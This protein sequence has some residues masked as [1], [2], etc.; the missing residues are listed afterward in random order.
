MIL[1]EDLRYISK[2]FG[3]A[4]CFTGKSVFLTGAAGFL[5]FYFS[6]FFSRAGVRRLLLADT[7]LLERPAWIDALG[8]LPQV[9]V[10]TLNV[11]RED[12]TRIPG[13]GEV[14]YVVH[15]AS[16][17]SPTYYRRYPIETIQANVLGLLHLLELYKGENLKGF[18]F[19]SSSEI[20]GDP[21]PAFIPT[22]EEYRG[23]VA[24]IGPRACYD[25]SKRI[26]ET[27][28]FHYGQTYTMPIGVAR[29]FNNYGPG[30][31]LEDKRVPADFA[32]AILDG[33]DILIRSDGRPTRTY[34]YVADA[35]VGYLK[36][37][38]HGKYDYFN[39]GME[40]PEISVAQ[41][42]EIYLELGKR[43]FGYR[44]RVRYEASAEKDYMTDNPNRRCP[45]IDKA[46]SILGYDPEIT[47]AEGVE[48]F[49]RFHQEGRR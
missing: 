22:P 11:A 12:L 21:D 30:M 18:L 13:I 10:L 26:G 48:K 38:T 43:H 36:I 41:L 32:K 19:F 27:I 3:S 16:I 33:E 2:K 15:M 44:G 31:R 39:I 28:C 7:F 1:E 6:H 40:K 23:N 49:L 9:E 29:P 14:D 34:C 17:A 4:E 20:Y 35:M 25:E 46:R 8:R 5:G 37:L 24:C 45:R 42:A 47:V